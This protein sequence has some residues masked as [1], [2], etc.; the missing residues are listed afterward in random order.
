MVILTPFSWLANP[1]ERIY[2]AKDSNSNPSRA[3]SH[4]MEGYWTSKALART[5]VSDFVATHNPPF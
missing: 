5:A 1:D 4:A 3:V 2:T